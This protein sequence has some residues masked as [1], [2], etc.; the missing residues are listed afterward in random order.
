MAAAGKAI[1]ALQEHTGGAFGAGLVLVVVPSVALYYGIDRFSQHPMIG[2]PIMA[3]FGIMI[4]FGAL[5]LVSTVFAR[6]GL[7]NRLEAL[8]LPEGSIRAAIALALVVLFAIIAIML[9]QSVADPYVIPDLSDADK[10]LLLHDQ[11]NRVIA[12]QAHCAKPA[13][14][15]ATPCPDLRFQVHLQRPRDPDTTDLAKQLLVM[16]GTLMTSVTSFYFGSRSSSPSKSEPDPTQAAPENGAAPDEHADGCGTAPAHPTPD[17][18]LPP[19]K[20]GV[21]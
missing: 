3:I 4:L 8:A 2:L 9:Y 17:H 21:A 6:L 12:V 14:A 10:E 16:V 1:S 7:D 19:A 13:A 11:H 15:V 5:A 18:Q 20:G